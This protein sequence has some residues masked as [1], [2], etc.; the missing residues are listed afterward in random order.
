MGASAGE[1]ARSVQARPAMSR[2]RSRGRWGRPLAAVRR[3]AEASGILEL[4]GPAGRRKQGR[5]PR[6]T[7][8]Y[9]LALDCLANWLRIG[10]AFPPRCERSERGHRECDAKRAR[11]QG[12]R[13]EASTFTGRA[14]RSERTATLPG[15]KQA[16]SS[17]IVDSRVSL[18]SAAPQLNQHHDF[19]FIYQC[20]ALDTFTALCLLV[21]DKK[22]G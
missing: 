20:R 6:V 11:S 1:P 12:V 14:M 3:R 9:P 19:T 18:H 10:G 2:I 15:G 5:R 17:I 13:C 22:T 4:Q 21:N 7:A 16:W 8:C